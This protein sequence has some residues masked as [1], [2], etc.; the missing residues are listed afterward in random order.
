MS[1]SGDPTLLAGILYYCQ[2]GYF[3][4]VQ[5]AAI[6][7]L[8]KS[9]NDAVLQFF[10]AYGLLREERIRDAIGELENI[11]NRP[12]VSLCS[13][14]ALIYAHKRCE[15]V[16]REAV[17][18]LER[19]LKETR[20][21]AGE[22]ALYY[23]ALFLWLLGRQ[24]KAREY[25]DRMLK[26]SKGSREG[27]VL[28]GWLELCPEQPAAGKKAI[29]LLDQGVQDAKDAFG[30]LGKVSYFM[31]QQNYAGALE[32]VNQMTASFSHFIPA[33]VLRMKLFLA[34]QDWEQAVEAG[35]R[36]LEKDLSN[37]DARQ[38][39]AVHALAREGSGSSTIDHVRNLIKALE[40]REPQNP[41]LHLKKIRV[42][43]RLSGRNP[44]ILQHISGLMERTF[45]MAPS[46]AL[47]ATELAY[48]LLIQGKVKEASQWYTEAMKL[49]ESSLTALTG[50]IRCQVL[51]GRLEEAEQ[52]LEFLQE[53][54]Q[55]SGK[56]KVLLYLQAVL[57]SRGQKSEQST[58][59]LLEEAAELHFSCLRGLPLGMEYLERLNPL[60][61]ADLVKELLAFC[62]KQPRPPGQIVSPLLKQAALILS[63]VIQVAP[64]LLEPLYLMAQVNYLSGE[65]DTAQSTLQ[66]CIDMHH[67][68][69]DAH[70]LMAQ[71]YLAQGNSK[72]CSHLLELGVS[73]NFQVRDQPLY[74]LIKARALNQ[75]GD[76]P[77]AIKTLKM[78]L[79]LPGLKKGEGRKVHRTA[80]PPSER[81]SVLLELVEA[82]RL[83]GE[84]HEATKVMQDTINE[85][86]GTPEEIRVTIANVD[87][88]LSKGQVDLA[89]S[90][91]RGVTPDQP[92]YTEAKE[93]MARIYLQT[94]KDPR[95]FIGCYRDLCDHLPGPHSSL[96]LGDAF[97]TI[98][99]PEKA[100]EVYDQ[101]YRKNPHDASLISRIGQA[102]VKTHQYGKAISYY[103]AAQKMS[104]QES[105]RWDLAQLLLKLRKFSKAEKVLQ[106]ALEH[107]S[108]NDVPSMMN[109]VKCL[110]LLAQV[111]KGNKNE[112][113]LGT[114][115]KALDLQT[116][117]LKRLPLEQA[118]MIPAQKRR[119]AELWGLAGEQLAAR[120]DLA[121]AAQRFREALALCPGD[122]RVMLQQA[123][124]CLLQ[125]DL[126]ACEHQ[127]S[128]LLQEDR[129]NGAAAVLL[130][131]LMFR[132]QKY[133]AAVSLYRRVLEREPDKF[134][135]LNKLIDLLRRSGKMDEAPAFFE[136]VERPS[137]HLSL[138]PGYNYCKGVYYWRVGRPNEALRSL[139]KARRD[140]TWGLGATS[141]MVQICLNPDNE[142]VGGEVFEKM[143]E[144]ASYSAEES[145][146]LGVRTAERLLRE[147]CPRT[148]DE[149]TQLKML[150]GACLLVSR[151][152]PSLEQALSTFIQVAQ[153]ERDNASAILAVA[154]AYMILKQVP[155]A[156]TQLKRLA[157]VP[158]NLR[159]AESL[160]QAW[161]LL[162]DVC[163]LRGKFDVA[164]ELL[165]RCL[166]YN[167][168]CSKAYEYLGFVM[169]KEQAYKDA[170]VNYELAWKY[171][172]GANPVIGYKLAFNYLKDRRYVEAIE[173]CHK[174]LSEFPHYPRIK[175]EILEKAQGALKP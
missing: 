64:A 157:K 23:A 143:G 107:D 127:C 39:L 19:E 42:V 123:Q 129:D 1:P 13:I 77:E 152:K 83:N 163:C 116:R 154:Q 78:V 18:D 80:M 60:F 36:I 46:E 96:L 132:K 170:A 27:Y 155:K 17:L 124:L 44:M 137:N 82:L 173:V 8:E 4:H 24:D 48:Q 63:P 55:S 145:L 156:R 114:L 158:W 174:V 110:L 29:K 131:D 22:K 40:T 92:C 74:H 50:I 138:E 165:R 34:Q 15:T 47:F 120:G 109:D 126:D 25:A 175:E 111:Y 167:Q 26:L 28:R 79:K 75:K 171:S 122:Q 70:L 119:A 168:S 93:K 38:L 33:L 166:Q 59:M 144:E 72:M 134:C 161:I 68:S 103:E 105:L 121:K 45:L 67:T 10:K 7:G 139:N 172:N 147:F 150:Q 140:S 118:E 125:G 30:L 90:M 53:V 73:H 142:V 164:S 65:L 14:M 106:Q 71:V 2:E 52:Q 21:A 133:T 12:D 162:A 85:F 56:C 149:H 11:R 5:N 66:R 37:L 135:V 61:L 130:A 99:E 31:L 153:A 54:Q 115:D 95:L 91:L 62:P 69:P 113:V 58:T 136:L 117:V 57:A 86:S 102:Y 104:G 20:K 51:E 3:R 84:L 87:L 159:D 41:N 169:E 151:D 81:V 89:V 76:Y 160:E 16:D 35:H 32:V 43:S 148:E 100:L 146:Q 128:A 141:L 49:D 101:A 108:A 6:E 112:A 88:A 94:R 97:M 9:P 98:Q